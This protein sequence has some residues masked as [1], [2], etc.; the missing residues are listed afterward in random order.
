MEIFWQDLRFGVRML[1]RNSGITIAAI[2]TLALGIGANTAI[3]TIINGILIQPLHFAG[4]A[5]YHHTP[6]DAGLRVILVDLEGDTVARD[7]RRQLH[8]RV[9][10]K[11]DGLIVDEIV[12]QISSLFVIVFGLDL[13]IEV[14]LRSLLLW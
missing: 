4:L 5:R 10:A 14:L 3:F 12:V 2:L 1:W 11:N 6:S 9:G 7:R 8:A 13:P